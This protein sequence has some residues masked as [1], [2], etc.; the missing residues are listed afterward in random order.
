MSTFAKIWNLGDAASWAAAGTD[1]KPRLE[2]TA[3][4]PDSGDSIASLILRI[5]TAASGGAAAATYT[6][7]GATLATALANG[8]YDAAY[9]MLNKDQASSERWWTIE[10]TD[11]LGESSGESSRTAFKVCW[12][13]AMYEHAPTGGAT[14]SAW[15]FASAAITTGQDVAYLFRNAT[16]A[17]GAGAGAWQASIGGVTPAAYVNVLV[18]LSTYTAGTNAPLPDMTFSY[19]AS[20][21]QPPDH[22]TA[23]PSTDWLLD[24]GKYRFGNKSYHARV[25]SNV[26]DYYIYPFRVTANDDLVVQPDTDFVFSCYVAV[27]RDLIA[28]VISLRVYAGG[29]MSTLLAQGATGPDALDEGSGATSNP[30]TDIRS[31]EGW[32][33]LH[34]H[35]HV[36]LGVTSIRPVIYYDNG[37]AGNGDEFW[38]DATEM[39]EGNVVSAWKPGFLSSALVF[40]SYGIRID[41][42]LGGT[43]RLRNT[44][45][46]QTVTLDDVVSAAGS[47]HPD[48]AT[49]DALGLAT[50]AELATHAAAADPHTGYQ[51][52]SERAAASGYAS[53]D[54]GTKV[55][56]AQ[57]PTGT[58]AATVALGDAA[59]ALDATHTALPNAHHAESHVLATDTALGPAHTIT[60][61]V[62]GYVLRAL[63]ATT[64]KFMQLVHA[65]LGSIGADDHHAQ[66]HTHASHTGIGA[67][68]H[69]GQ[70][71]VLATEL[72]LGA[73]HTITGGVAG[74]VLRALTATTAKFMQLVHSDLGSVGANDHHSQAHAVSG[75][76]HTG[77]VAAAQMP[78]LTGDV[79]TVAGAV[80]T[81]IG[82]GKVTLAMQ[83]N[84]AVDTLIGRATA[85][86]GVPEAIALTAAARTVLD[87]ATVAAMLATLGGAAWTAWAA[88]TPTLQFG[89]ASVGITY[90]AQQGR[91]CQVGNVVHFRLRVTLTAKGSS[92]GAAQIAGLPVAAGVTIPHPVV[93]GY[94]SGMS[95]I[96]NPILG[97]IAA[98]GAAVVLTQG[99]GNAQLTDANFG[100]TSDIIVSGSYEV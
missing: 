76:D 21:D 54:A 57:L 59:A 80:A 96:T 27:N 34:L 49:H 70:S 46:T 84:L 92:T 13:Q 97:R 41:G 32:L 43:L 29:G 31:E 83:A 53:L 93:V 81:T 12:G 10:A 68:D 2:F 36:P 44:A 16:G 33:R 85:G 78:A 30:L 47:G 60:G 40:D 3:S 91:Y 62:A 14:S 24:T 74:Y 18:R 19:N 77:S 25:D 87:D 75:A 82:A 69:H 7:T 50:D 15:Q 66:S 35:V 61:G 100:A 4:D 67:N 73:D 8:Y 39:E 90:S 22:W 88:F 58:T 38:V 1:A 23:V 48:L 64:A 51:K 11:A 42:S 95:T 28:S 37:G 79:T 6:L 17:A 52:E 65:D 94:W 63:S 55:P 99:S 89:G 86:T 9:G 5:Y 26:D 98:T 45:G 71:H 72:A 20:A 56:L